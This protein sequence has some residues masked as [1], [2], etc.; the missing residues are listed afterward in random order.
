MA[1]YEDTILQMKK[2][3]ANLAQWVEAGAAFA[4]KK[5]FDPNVL[6]SLRLYPD[7]YPLVRQVQAV[8]DTAKFTAARLSGKE[9]PRHPDT[10]QTID[11]IKARIAAVTAYLD[12]FKADDFKGC[13]ERQIELPWLEGKVL[14][15]RDYLYTLQVPNF[16]FHATTAYDILRHNGVEL[17]KRDFIGS[18][19]IR[20]KA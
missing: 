10:E 2:T 20:D 7:M 13:E 19:P 8:C 15:G 6:L 3:L 11:E 5:S 17:G 1:V 14:L 12:T 9:A 4:Q 16:Y 18:L